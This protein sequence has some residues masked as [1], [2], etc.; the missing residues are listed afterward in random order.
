MMM[1]IIQDGSGLTNGAGDQG[2][3]PAVLGWFALS[4]VVALG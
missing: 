3:S 2:V 4:I 1:Q